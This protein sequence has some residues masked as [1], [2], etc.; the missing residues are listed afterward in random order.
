MDY[1]S[2]YYDDI[3]APRSDKPYNQLSY[4]FQSPV[5]WITLF[6]FLCMIVISI[7][8]LVLVIMTYNN[9]KKK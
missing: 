2:I 1:E 5:L 3:L 9:S 8:I 4:A 7:V 6:L